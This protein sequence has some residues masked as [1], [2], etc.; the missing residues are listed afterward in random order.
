MARYEVRVRTPAAG[1]GAAYWDLK[2]PAGRQARLLELGVSLVAA[3]ASLIGLAR[4][5]GGSVQ[6][7]SVVGQAVDPLSA[8][9][10]VTIGSAWSTPPVAPVAPA[11]YMRAFGLPAQ[12]GAGLIWTWGE[13]GL[14]VPVSAGLAIMNLGAAAGSALD[15]YAVWEE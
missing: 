10:T 11:Q 13:N 3:T 15:V 6:T 14:L 2:T 7:T 12:I 5:S 1:A 8:A 9:S 4:Q